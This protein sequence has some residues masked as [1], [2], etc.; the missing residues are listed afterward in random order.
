[1]LKQTIERANVDLSDFL[2]LLCFKFNRLNLLSMLEHTG[3]TGFLGFLD[4][5]AGCYMKVP[6]AG[7]IADL[8][9]RFRLLE[10]VRKMR[11]LQTNRDMAGWHD[12]EQQF[13]K[14]CGKL[15]VRY[16]T[17]RTIAT[18]IEKDLA[19]AKVWSKRLE[20]MKVR[21]DSAEV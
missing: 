1:M 17:G 18:T 2:I 11:I 12:V 5:F 13:I 8:L 9:D 6:P 3:T 7:Q 16:E 14:V 20:E 10:L 15:H 4:Q 19:K 21:Q